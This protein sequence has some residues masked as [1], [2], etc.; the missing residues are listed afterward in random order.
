MGARWGSSQC[1]CGFLFV[2]CTL[3]NTVLLCVTQTSRKERKSPTSYRQASRMLLYLCFLCLL[4]FK[5]VRHHRMT[6]LTLKPLNS[7]V[8]YLGVCCKVGGF[9]GVLVVKSPPANAEDIRDS[10]STPGL[11]RSPGGGHGNPFQ[12][13]YLENPMDRGTWRATVYRVTK[14][15]TRLKQLSTRAK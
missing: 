10:G 7:S 8:I 5:E 12:Y 9:Q 1:S 14:S 13:S 2:F 4:H 3:N 15:R 6:S 11:G